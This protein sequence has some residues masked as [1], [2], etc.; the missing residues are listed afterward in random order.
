MSHSVYT[1]DFK[2][3]QINICFI[4][5]AGYDAISDSSFSAVIKFLNNKPYGDI[6]HPS[7]SSLSS[8]C[9]EYVRLFL[10]DQYNSGA[11]N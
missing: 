1:V 10:M 9:R 6:L 3:T 7:R 11:Y 8:E 2:K 4:E 5:I